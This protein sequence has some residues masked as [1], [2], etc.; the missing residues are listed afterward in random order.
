ELRRQVTSPGG[1]TERALAS[2][3]A[4]DLGGVVLRA[5]TAARD[6]GRELAAQ[7]AR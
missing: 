6:R 1:T 7:V 3:A 2:F 4:D 5:L